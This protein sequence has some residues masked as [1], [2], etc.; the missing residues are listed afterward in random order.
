[1]AEVENLFC[2]DAVVRLTAKKLS[3]DPEHTSRA[4]AAFL[5]D[6]LT[7]EL[8]AQIVMHAE[9]RIRYQL[10]TY[11]KA[12]SDEQ[13]LQKGIDDLLLGV[14][15]SATVSEARNA[16]ADALASADPSKILRVYN[17]KTLAERMSSCFGLNRGE[18]PQLVIRAMKG[19]DGAPFLSA[20]RSSLPTL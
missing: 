13:G 1:M 4:A 3:L 19:A 5:T 7:S 20:F 16:L 18:Y 17:R 2:L 6:A 15:V 12:S 11:S 14:N 10:S 9:R 8:E